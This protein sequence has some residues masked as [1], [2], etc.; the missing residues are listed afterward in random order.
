MNVLIYIMIFYVG[1]MV[2]RMKKS[3]DKL[4]VDHIFNLKCLTSNK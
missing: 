1:L 4:I 3:E 2:Q